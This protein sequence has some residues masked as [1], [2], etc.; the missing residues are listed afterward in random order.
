MKGLKKSVTEGKNGVRK[1]TFKKFRLFTEEA[2][3]L[4][5]LKSINC[6]CHG[7]KIRRGVGNV[8]HYREN[9]IPVVI[10]VGDQE[11]VAA[12]D[13]RLRPDSATAVFV[14]ADGYVY[15]PDNYNVGVQE[16]YVGD[17][18][19]YHSLRFGDSDV[20]HLIVGDKGACYTRDGQNFTTLYHKNFK[21]GCVAGNRFFLLEEN[22]TVYYSAA[23]DPS[24]WEGDAAE[25]GEIYLPVEG[26][27]P[28]AIAEY[29]NY[30][31]I[32]TERVPYRITV[33]A[34]A[35]EFVLE[36][37]SY[38]GGE[39]IENSALAVGTDIFFL[40]VNGLYR[41][42]GDRVEKIC[43]QLPIHPDVAAKA[44]WGIC[45]DTVIWH[46]FDEDL[47]WKRLVAYADGS[48][49]FFADTYGLPCGGE[50]FCYSGLMC[51]FV[52][53]SSDRLILE[54]PFFQSDWENL[55]TEKQK[56][57]RKLSLKGKGKVRV[58]VDNGGWYNEYNFTLNGGE[59]SVNLCKK[60]KVFSFHIFPQAG[61]E[62]SG[63]SVEYTY[64]DK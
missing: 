37:I 2:G 55:G 12:Y 63:M 39:V 7:G 4:T 57:L 5:A 33:K 13:I 24:K 40:S 14:A 64:L 49:G 54:P 23:A 62:V 56:T 22:G 20:Y 41:I 59:G 28:K 45:E 29:G 8:P 61:S 3:G 36:K 44:R 32:F 48:D 47:Q 35:S 31:Y 52:K 19:S 18:T 11:I 42:Q 58:R 6:D 38:D 26:G 53:T 51:R 30:V 25:G 27:K 10:D 50:Y 21:G 15:A 9:G 17:Y 16:C 34:K 43:K 46:Y 1:V 60:G